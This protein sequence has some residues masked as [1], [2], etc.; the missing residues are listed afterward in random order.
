GTPIAVIAPWRL[1]LLVI[2]LPGLLWS[3]AI[4][5][6]REPQR[7]AAIAQ[8][9]P[10]ARGAS[11]RHAAMLWRV[12]TFYIVVATAS[13]FY[14]VVGCWST[15]RLTPRRPTSSWPPCHSTSPSRESSRPAASPRYWMWCRTGNAASRWRSASS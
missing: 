13:L 1:V 5:L 2:G 9:A 10:G 12:A 11:G 4:L 6:I 7:R 8:N 14:Y 3:L 15:G